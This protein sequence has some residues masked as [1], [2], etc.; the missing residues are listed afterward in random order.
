MMERFPDIEVYLAQL[1]LDDINAW[2]HTTLNAA[3]LSPAGKG[4]WKTRGQH[5]G[6]TVPV[7]LVVL[8]NTSCPVLRANHE[9]ATSTLMSGFSCS[10]NLINVPPNSVTFQ[11]CGIEV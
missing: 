2:L 1:T 6:E 9:S 10:S 3:P 8:T 4:K 5:Q 7:L 11:T